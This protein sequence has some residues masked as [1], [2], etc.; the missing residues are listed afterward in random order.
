MTLFL[1]QF[2]SSDEKA[3]GKIIIHIPLF[4]SEGE[5]VLSGILI[6]EPT[7][8]GGNKW[9]T[10]L[11]DITSDLNDLQSLWGAE[12][13][14]SWIG[15]SVQCWK[16]TDPLK[17]SADFFVVNYSPNLGLESKIKN[18]FALTSMGEGQFAGGSTNIQVHG[19]YR[20]DV[21]ADNNDQFN[22]RITN[23]EE[24]TGEASPFKDQ[25][26]K[27]MEGSWQGEGTVAVEIGER[28]SFSKLLVSSVHITPST[29]EVCDAF[30]NNVKPLYYRINVTFIG[31]RALLKTDVDNFII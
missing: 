29:L 8:A 1:E 10:I 30:G 18:L 19:G 3:P 11:G 15:A 28:I 2:Y 21:L 17:F 22:A 31:S 9:G 27:V 5:D 6:S 24:L 20:P 12:N 23:I 13:M 26:K 7:F 14:F 16:G 4:N 25:G